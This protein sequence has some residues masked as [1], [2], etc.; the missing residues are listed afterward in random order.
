MKKIFTP[1]LIVLLGGSAIA[2]WSPT[3]YK[4]R[5]S[6]AVD[7]NA[8][9]KAYFKLDID[10]IREQ[11]KDAQESGP[12]S[13]P[14]LISM[15]TLR[16]KIETYKVY[17]FPVMAKE[18][19]DQYQLGS[20]VGVSV[21]DPSKF[22]RFSTAPNDFQSM[23]IHNGQ[24]EFI[25]PIDKSTSTY[26][27]HAKTNNTGGKSFVCSTQE[28]PA[29]T[30]QIEKLLEKG[31]SFTND[32][33]VFSKNSDK[34]YRTMRLALSTTGE[35]T[36]FFG[37]TTG[38]M[39]QINATLTRVNGVFEKD[40]AL[41]LNMQNYPSLI[42]TNAAT[43][44]YT[45]NLNLQL[46][47]N[48]TAVVGDANYDIGHIFNAAG[49]NGNAGCIGCVCINPS[50]SMPR[51]KGS[52]FT[53]STNPSGDAFDID[54]VAHEIGHQLGANHTFAH[55]L[56]GTGVNVEPGSG[57]TIM[58]YA[59]IT[60]AT[61]DVQPHSDPYF[62][63]VSIDQVQAN[64]NIKTCDVETPIANNP[65]V[66]TALPSYTIPKSTAFVLTAS[67]TDPENDP[68]TYTWEQVDNA[69]V[70]IDKNNIG[71]T[72]TGATF[73]SVNPTTV[74]TRYFP[75]F[76]SVLAG[77]L[78]NTNNTWESVSKVARATNFAITARDNNGV[79][80]QQQTSS[81]QQAIT[82]GA[83]G[84]FQITS[85]YL[86]TNTNSPLTW[87]VANT[88]AAPYN[89]ANVAIDYSTDN[90]VSWTVLTASTPND[91]SESFTMPTALNGQTIVMRISALQNVFYA[92]KKV[93]VTT[94]SSCGSVP[95]G[96]VAQN[97][98]SSGATITW[99]PISGASSYVVR[100]KKITDAVW[101]EVTSVAANI[102]LSGLFDGS[103]YEVQVAAVCSGVTGQ[104]SPSTNFSTNT[105]NY[106][107]VALGNA[108]DD[109]IANVTLANLNNTSGPSTYTNY[110]T[111]PTKQVNLVLGNTYTL[112]VTKGWSSAPVPNMVSA[113]LDFNK[114]GVFSDSERVMTITNATANTQNPVTATFTVPANAVVG[115]AFRMRIIDAY[116]NQPGYYIGDACGLLNTY[117]E[118]EDY[119]VM[120]ST[121]LSTSDIAHSNDGIKIYPNPVSD[122]L[123]ITKVSDKAD[124]TIHNAA[125]QLVDRGTIKDGKINVSSL[126]KGVYMLTIEDG[127]KEA[128]TTK[129]IK[130]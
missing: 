68:M 122:V 129:I 90:G 69:T 80:A 17:S 36:T 91:G 16:G 130:K 102:T 119:N 86:F 58:G 47:Q 11:L 79:A 18:L 64:L 74:P 45:G 4:E 32:P 99:A 118:A 62:H 21:D 8:L 29:Y 1:L 87:D 71:T 54:F 88:S 112:S 41:H 123:N 56:E 95:T 33:S 109:H 2:Q 104:Y 103:N 46:Q 50:A 67:V 19:A 63:K 92:L 98:S 43:D 106:C 81:A 35:Y 72:A 121:N 115:Q 100:Y 76:S 12:N 48:L 27:V 37:G 31:S 57:S 108:T 25:S 89:V 44:P 93:V 24:Y 70:V 53:Q 30:K 10:K 111:D 55:G 60:G 116:Y 117:G 113:W 26:A 77:V 65:P 22:L 107:S 5:S 110:T 85:G 39:T 120:V 105:V 66:I 34:K 14:V 75:K 97:V 94:Q 51:A 128:F 83:D 127:N 38:A 9:D 20:Y 13:K 3:S 78:D 15:P 7:T 125:G 6:K 124:F 52:G 84:P 73:R 49:N 59:G 101:Q 114:D 42:Y 28:D 40:F 82:V 61:T 23:I 126:V 96:V